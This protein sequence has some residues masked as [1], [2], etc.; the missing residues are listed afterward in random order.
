MTA[1]TLTKQE[2]ETLHRL[3][4]RAISDALPESVH[5]VLFIFDEEA[6]DRAQVCSDVPQPEAAKVVAGFLKL[7]IGQLRQEQSS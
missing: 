4:A 7:V 1:K 2:L 6:P 3:I 5:F